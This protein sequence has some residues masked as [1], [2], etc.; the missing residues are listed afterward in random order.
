MA[1]LAC[2][3]K[4]RRR[5]AVKIIKPNHILDRYSIFV[6][7]WLADGSH[8]RVYYLSY[9]RENQYENGQM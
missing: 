2:E 3:E 8:Q 1:R 4:S 6:A 7:R 9:M 5:A